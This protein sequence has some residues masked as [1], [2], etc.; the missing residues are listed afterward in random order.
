MY[1]RSRFAASGHSIRLQVTVPL[2]P[3]ARRTNRIY[4]FCN[5]RNQIF[6]FEPCIYCMRR[7][8]ASLRAHGRGGHDFMCLTIVDLNDERVEWSVYCPSLKEYND[9]SFPNLDYCSDLVITSY[10]LRLVASA[11][12]TCATVGY[13][14][15]SSAFP[16]RTIMHTS[17]YAQLNAA[18]FP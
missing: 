18:S 14:N 7:K 17:P 5:F 12:P 13:A 16:M 15:L 4:V 10:H 9:S 2:A 6:I 11:L 8:A 1:V 3:Q